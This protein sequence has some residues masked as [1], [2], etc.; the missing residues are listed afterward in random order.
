MQVLEHLSKLEDEFQRYFPE[1]DMTRDY[2]SFARDPFS[3]EV[4]NVPQDFQ[5]E[6]LELKNCINNRLRICINN[7]H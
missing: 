4:H 2:L 1:V 3:A 5:E 7:P 6:I